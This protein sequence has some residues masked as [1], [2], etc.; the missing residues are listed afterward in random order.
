MTAH[1]CN[2]TDER[3]TIDRAC[4]T[5]RVEHRDGIRIA[6]CPAFDPVNAASLPADAS[7]PL[8]VALWTDDLDLTNVDAEIIRRS[9][10]ER[11]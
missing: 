8:H 3:E 2:R 9:A 4:S 6:K 7:A 1:R 10:P 11:M 5:T